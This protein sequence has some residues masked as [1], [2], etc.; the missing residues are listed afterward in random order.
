LARDNTQKVVN[1]MIEGLAD[2]TADKRAKSAQI[3]ASFLVYTEDKITGYVA[4]ILGALYKIMAGDEPHVMNEVYFNS[5]W[6]LLSSRLI[7][8]PCY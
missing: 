7:S 6:L 4:S 2:W 1:K 8:S 3:L 5:P